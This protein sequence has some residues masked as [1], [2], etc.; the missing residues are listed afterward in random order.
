[1][2]PVGIRY[3]LAASVLF[4]IMAV[5][6]KSLSGIPV[7][8]IVFFR[9]LVSGIICLASLLR[10]GVRPWGNRKRLLLLRGLFGTGALLGFFHTLQVAPLATAVTIQYL[11]PVFT[12]LFA[13]LLL[14]E[15]LHPMQ[16]A[17]FALAMLGVVVIKGFD[18]RV[19][20]EVVFWGVFSAACSGMAYTLVRKLR[21]SDRA[22]VVVFYFPL[23]TV[24]LVGP[25]T[26]MHWKAPSLDEWGMLL[27][28]GVVVT[29]AQICLTKA[30][31]TEKAATVSI[32]RYLGTVYAMFFGWVL[33]DEAIPLMS[34]V[35]I[36]LIVAGVLLSTRFRYT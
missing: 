30:F 13:A 18:P 5:Q 25:Y 21:E 29:F 19:S 35:G 24:P 16:V 34:L 23:V 10:L 2:I 31:Q 20:L 6:V 27:G 9:S 3:I 33:F 32:F 15:R 36:I 17:C 8:E 4:S 11:S 14:K 7:H 12:A 1:M 28:V 22:L 26:A